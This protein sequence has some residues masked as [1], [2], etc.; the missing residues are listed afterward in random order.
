MKK[1][2]LTLALALVALA[3]SAQ[4]RLAANQHLVGYYTSDEVDN[5]VGITT[6][7]GKM[8]AGCYL[9]KSDFA[10]YIGAKVVGMR[11]AL[12]TDA[13]STGVTVHGVTPQN[14]YKQLLSVDVDNEGAGWHTVMFDTDKQFNLSEDYKAIVPSYKYTQTRK[15]YPIGVYKDGPKRDL[16]IYGNVR[17]TG[18]S[19]SREEW[20]NMGDGYGTIAVQLIVETDQVLDNAVT[21]RDFGTYRVALG[22]RKKVDV[23][24]SNLGAKLTDFDYTITMDDKTSDAYHVTI[25]ADQQAGA[26]T[27]TLP[28]ELPSAAAL[29]TYPVK[30]TVTKVN[31]VENQAVAT[32]A[33]GTC[34]TVFKEFVQRVFVEEM[35]GTG[36]GWC[37]R[38]IVGMQNLAK[39]LGDRFVG[40]A[41]HRY[42]AST[43]PMAPREYIK[44]NNLAAGSAPLCIV[45]RKGQSFDPY[46]GTSQTPLG[47][48]Y[49]VAPYLDNTAEVGVSVAGVWNED[50]TE[51]TATAV[52]ESNIAGNYDI[53][54]ILVADSLYGDN[55]AW[56][57]NNNFAQYT[58]GEGEYGTDVNLQQFC[59]GGE[60]GANPIRNLAYDDV[61]IAASYNSSSTLA[62]LDP[63][64]AGCTV[65][66]SY[67]LRMP[68]KNSLKPYVNKD[69]VSVIAVI[70][71]KATGYVVNVA[72]NSHISA[73]AGVE[74]VGQLGT[75][76][77]E[78]A[79][80]NAAGQRISA[81]QKGLNI[82]RYSNGKTVKV[83]VR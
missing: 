5:S 47:S 20:N 70:T 1:T 53:A 59:K 56:G 61:V 45:N 69:K 64:T 58:I 8:Q 39:T 22:Q 14:T 4:Q 23:T 7:P 49:D 43:D 6:A 30:L 73:L 62:T 38:G 12:G 76:A 67:T 79:R 60:H 11:F 81:P 74:S 57:Q 36:C 63:L 51:V 18:G 10:Q 19:A 32:S 82:V 15:N 2:I 75:E 34:T 28:I 24:F 83:L 9:L 37:P 13:K 46:Y 40:V 33:S 65:T 35:T 16:Y 68:T 44:L 48:Y 55:A 41:I 54:F 3:V 72:K 66:S 27:I 42:N 21:P 31:G 17:G 29:G 52:V 78:V 50:Q 80:Y 26:Q 25:P 77:E 71:D